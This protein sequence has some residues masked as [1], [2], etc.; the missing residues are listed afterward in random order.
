MPTTLPTSERRSSSDISGLPISPVGPVTATASDTSPPSGW[1]S[2]SGRGYAVSV[3]NALDVSKPGDAVLELLRIADLD[4]ELV[5][6]HRVVGHAGGADDVD[7]RLGESPREVLEQASAVVGVDLQLDP[8]GGLVFAFPSHLDEAL[9]RL[10]QR[11]DVLAVGA[12]DGDPA[13]ERDVAGD[14]VAGD[15]P[16]ALRQPHGDVVG[17]LDDDPVVGGVLGAAGAVLAAERRPGGVLLDP[18]A[19]FQAL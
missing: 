3:E 17:A 12:V 15:R 19:G 1:P 4:H 11:L 13:P 9:R 2:S 16:A 5:F 18:L 7:P 10:F 14:L 8:V 6:H